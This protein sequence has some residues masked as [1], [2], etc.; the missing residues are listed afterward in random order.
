M[1]FGGNMSDDDGDLFGAA[2]LPVLGDALGIA[3]A[4]NQ[5]TSRPY[6]PAALPGVV[7]VGGSPTA[8]HGSRT[9]AVGSTHV[10]RLSTS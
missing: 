8:R 3:A 10:H 6:F 9:S 1:S 7:A 5:S 4:G 2:L